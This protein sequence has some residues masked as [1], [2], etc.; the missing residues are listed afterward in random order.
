[1]NDGTPSGFRP[2]LPTAPLRQKVPKRAPRSIPDALWDELFAAVGSDRDRSLLAFD[3]SSGARATELLE[4]I[5]ERID[6]VANGFR[7]CR[8][9]AARCR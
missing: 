3:V 2:T 7:W 9:E 8:R 1:M 6:W 4:L 5:G